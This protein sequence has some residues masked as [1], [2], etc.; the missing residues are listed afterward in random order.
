MD[1]MSEDD[2]KQLTEAELLTV[3]I[4]ELSR[5]AQSTLKYQIRFER[6]GNYDDPGGL[7]NV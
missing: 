3:L 7:E 5:M 1:W 6:H 2:S 4:G